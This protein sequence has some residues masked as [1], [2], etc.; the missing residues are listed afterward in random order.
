MNICVCAYTLLL[1]C[2]KMLLHCLIRQIINACLLR[3]QKISNTTVS[4]LLGTRVQHNAIRHRCEYIFFKYFSVI[5]R[6]RC[7]KKIVFLQMSSQRRR[8]TL[9]I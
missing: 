1:H 6:N 7:K 2:L 9:I 3:V 4:S 5:H 8:I